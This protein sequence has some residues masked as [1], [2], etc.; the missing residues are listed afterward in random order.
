MLETANIFVT[1]GAGTLGKAIAR[2]RKEL[3]WKGKMTVYSTDSHKHDLMRRSY[4]DIQYIPGDIRM[5]EPLY[6]AMVGH[7]VVIHAAAVKRIPEAE[8]YA[9]DCFDVNVNGSQN[10]CFTALRAGVREVLGISTDKAC[11]PANNY[12]ASKLI[13][14][15]IFQEYAALDT[16]TSFHLVRY[17]NVLESTGSVIETWR[18]AESRGETIKITDEHMTRFWLSPRQ[19]VDYVIDS[20]RLNS[21]LIYVPKMPALSIGKLVQYALE[22]EWRSLAFENIPLRPGEKMHETLVTVDELPR[23]VERYI[24]KDVLSWFVVSPSTNPKRYPWKK[25]EL[26]KYDDGS[27][28]ALIPKEP[29]SSDVAHE[30]TREELQKLLEDA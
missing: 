26:G 2:R 23:T 13:M 8:Y 28:K 29:Y 17:G 4:P 25:N 20:F 16:F 7:D 1:G 10:V 18:N 30:L 11:H 15:K 3:G 24:P 14:E 27:I 5:H 22:K 21:G 12:G 19:A 9:T 6:N